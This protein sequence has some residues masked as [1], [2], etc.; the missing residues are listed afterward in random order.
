MKGVWHLVKSDGSMPDIF[1]IVV[2]LSSVIFED[3]AA[4]AWSNYFWFILVPHFVL[5]TDA[6][7]AYFRSLVACLSESHIQMI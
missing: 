6:T 1:A 7:F 3:G 4:L 2:H 5:P